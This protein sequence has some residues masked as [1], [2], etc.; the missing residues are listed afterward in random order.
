MKIVVVGGG[1]IGAS[2]AW[3]L[4]R[5]S[6]GEVTLL[7]RDRLGSGTTWHSAGN[8]TWKPLPDH[9]A[10]IDVCAGDDP[11][12]RG[13]RAGGRPAGCGP[14]GPSSRGARAARGF[15][16][17]RPRRRASARI[18]AR[19]LEP[20]EARRLS[21]LLDPAAAQGIWLNPLSGRVNPADLTAA[22]AAAAR[23]AGARIVEQVDGRAPRA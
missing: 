14:G 20:D 5:E 8:I 19:W 10:Q 7:E 2:I 22:Y 9:D 21:P 4:A 3:H 6:A 17:I 23:R 13:A 18:A 11:A 16:G 15:R 12:R 1:V